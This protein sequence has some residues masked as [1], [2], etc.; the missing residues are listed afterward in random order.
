MATV[1]GISLLELPVYSGVGAV[2]GD[3]YEFPSGML[4]TGRQQHGPISVTQRTN[5]HGSS[6]VTT[7]IIQLA[8]NEGRQAAQAMRCFWFFGHAQIGEL[9]Y[10]LID[11]ASYHQSVAEGWHRES[12]P[13]RFLLRCN[14]NRSR[15]S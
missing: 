11:R 4:H 1:G 9:S 8:H 14:T 13:S 5:L 7:E 10:D 6:T 15:V 3:Q 2:R 12:Q